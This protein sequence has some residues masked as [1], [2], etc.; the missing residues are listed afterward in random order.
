VRRMAGRVGCDKLVA[1]WNGS[2]AA[3]IGIRRRALAL[4]AAIRR[5]LIELSTG[6]AVEGTY[7]QKDC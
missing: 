1:A 4:L 6:E 5:L 2:L 3:V 7:K